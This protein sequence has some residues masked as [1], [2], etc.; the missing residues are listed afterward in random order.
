VPR[1]RELDHRMINGRRIIRGERQ[2]ESTG[3][4]VSVYSETFPPP[5]FPQD[6]YSP[7]WSSGF[8]PSERFHRTLAAHKAV[9]IIQANAEADALDAEA[10]RLD[11]A[12]FQATAATTRAQAV[13][14]RRA[15]TLAKPGDLFAAGDVTALA[16][17]VRVLGVYG[18]EIEALL[19]R[20]V[21]GDA[22]QVGA[23]ADLEI[24]DDERW[25]PAIQP[26]PVRNKA[27]LESGDGFVVS[28]FDLHRPDQDEP[29][30][31]RGCTIYTRRRNK[32]ETLTI[33]TLLVPGRDPRT[34]VFASVDNADLL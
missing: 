5:T 31:E 14:K 23:W 28:V 24:G 26:T 27:T 4:V 32:G 34:I 9:T 20:H 29:P 2:C 25:C 30:N 7:G 12:G 10:R 33:A 15:S 21:A 1:I 3:R 11:A 17:G 6:R 22:G 13:E 18:P 19:A 8:T 16:V